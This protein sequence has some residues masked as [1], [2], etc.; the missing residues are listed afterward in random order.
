VRQALRCDR[1]VGALFEHADAAHNSIHPDANYFQYTYDNLNRMD[2]VQ[3]NGSAAGASLIADYAYDPLSRRSGLTRTSPNVAGSSYGYDLASR[4]TALAH[5]LNAAT[6]DQS[7]TFENGDTHHLRRL[8]A[9]AS[10]CSI[11]SR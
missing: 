11:F 10:C 7:Y 9:R 2:Q 3:L 5:D 6:F 4:L 1:D 8:D